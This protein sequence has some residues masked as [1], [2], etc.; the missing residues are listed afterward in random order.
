MTN[1]Q[2]P[3]RVLALLKSG[4]DDAVGM[5]SFYKHQ[6]DEVAEFFETTFKRW[7]WLQKAMQID[8][9]REEQIAAASG[10]ERALSRTIEELEMPSGEYLVSVAGPQV[11]VKAL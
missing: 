10:V 9:G 8:Q 7:P 6:R 2:V 1:V 3:A 4:F 5:D 11:Q